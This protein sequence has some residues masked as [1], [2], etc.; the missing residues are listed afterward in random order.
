VLLCACAFQFA[1]KY[2]HRNQQLEKD[3]GVRKE[4]EQY[5]SLR[6]DVTTAF[7]QNL[8]TVGFPTTDDAIESAFRHVLQEHAAKFLASIMDRETT[9]FTA[10]GL[11]EILTSDCKPA[12][13]NQ[14]MLNRFVLR[15]VALGCWSSFSTA[16]TVVYLTLFICCWPCI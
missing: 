6:V 5:E 14:K 7:E 15:A 8:K 10:K 4:T 12:V 16:S 1:D 9:Q 3:A 11:R 2:L 13:D